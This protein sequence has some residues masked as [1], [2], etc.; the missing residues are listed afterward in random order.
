MTDHIPVPDGGVTDEPCAPDG[1]TRVVFSS[2]CDE[3][4]DC[5]FCHMDYSECPCPGPTQD[6]MDYEWFDGVLYA[7]ANGD[8]DASDP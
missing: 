1:W 7:R 5:P 4:G 8:P 6:G 3:E 2:E